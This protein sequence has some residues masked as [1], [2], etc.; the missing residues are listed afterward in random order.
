MQQNLPEILQ[1]RYINESGKPH[2]EVI[3]VNDGSIDDTQQVL[4]QFAA[5][6]EHLR[7]VHLNAE[8]ERDLPG[9]KYA[10]RAGV[11]AARHEWLLMTDAD[12]RPASLDWIRGMV[13]P[14]ASGKSIV[15]GYGPYESQPGLLNGFI[16]WET[17]H[18]LIFYGS[19]AQAGLPYMAVGRNLACKREL[20]EAASQSSIWSRLPSGDDDLLMRYAADNTNTAVVCTPETFTWSKSC[21]TWGEWMSQKQRHL[22]TGKYYRLPIKILLGGFALSHMA[23]WVLFFVLVF[24]AYAKAVLFLMGIRS[25]FYWGLIWGA[26]RKT[27][28][29]GHAFMYPLYDLGW[30]IY[31]LVFSPYILWKNKNRWT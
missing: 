25:L 28:A 21:K 11:T 1:Q 10:L 12:C 9:K 4:E 29:R 26:S 27:Q 19:F 31:N 30:M 8:Q 13:A 24:S 6:Y 23:V 7:V 5:K 15:A 14:L 17:L 3:V 22:S 20:M 18:T 16:R 2:F